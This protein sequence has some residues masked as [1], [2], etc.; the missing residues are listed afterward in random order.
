MICA[1]PRKTPLALILV[2]YRI[3]SNPALYPPPS[4]SVSALEAAQA[5]QHLRNPNAFR[6]SP[7]SA[8]AIPFVQHLCCRG[9]DLARDAVRGVR[10][11]GQF[12]DS[13]CEGVDGWFESG[14]D[15]ADTGRWC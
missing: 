14:G 5:P 9:Q 11:L 4:V 10:V 8:L 7:P 6:L 3:L 2:L 13:V 1:N 15:G 12:V